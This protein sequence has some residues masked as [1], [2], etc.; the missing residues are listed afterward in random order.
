MVLVFSF[1]FFLSDGEVSRPCDFHFGAGII[2]TPR[3]QRSLQET[4]NGQ[5]T[6]NEPIKHV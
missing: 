3:N 6:D 4:N 5:L 2:A 1:F